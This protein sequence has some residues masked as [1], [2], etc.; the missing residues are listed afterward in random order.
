MAMFL[1][2]FCLNWPGIN[3]ISPKTPICKKVALFFKIIAFVS[4]THL[5]NQRMINSARCFTPIRTRLFIASTWPIKPALPMWNSG[6]TNW[7]RV[8]RVIIVYQFIALRYRIIKE[9][10]NCKLI[11]SWNLDLVE[12]ISKNKAANDIH[13][14]LYIFMYSVQCTYSCMLDKR[15]KSCTLSSCPDL[16]L[17]D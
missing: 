14:C 2:L 7:L 5:A 6:C 13:T 10:L 9:P 15:D 8:R 16:T 4:G 17:P 12:C 3:Y 11:Q 1:R